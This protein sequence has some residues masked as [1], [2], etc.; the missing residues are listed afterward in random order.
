MTEQGEMFPKTKVDFA[1][2]FLE[3]FQADVESA[4]KSLVNAKA[5]LAAARLLRDDAEEN[6][7]RERVAAGIATAEEIALDMKRSA[8]EGG[9]GLSFSVNGGEE[10]VLAEPP[11]VDPNTGEVEGATVVA[12]YPGDGVHDTPVGPR[13]QYAEL[14]ADYLA[15]GGTGELEDYRVVAERELADPEKAYGRREP[16]EVI[17]TGDYGQ[18]L[19]IV[20]A[21]QASEDAA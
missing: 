5:K 14:I 17:W 19:R 6:L 8:E 9:Y 13:T 4:E 15:A 11:A 12:V 7:R 3:H 21:E 2:E 18:R 1:T 16:H 20:A 10:V